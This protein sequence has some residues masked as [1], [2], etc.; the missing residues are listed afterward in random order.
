MF[1]LSKIG[2]QLHV[3]IDMKD[4]I[5]KITKLELNNTDQN[6]M[7]NKCTIQTRKEEKWR[8]YTKSNLN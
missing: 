5:Q 1:S 3:A 6:K 2:Q 4:H 8:K 7:N